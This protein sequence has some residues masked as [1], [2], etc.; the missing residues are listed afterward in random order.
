MD[1]HTLI[2]QLSD[3]ARK[4]GAE[5]L[6]FYRSD[7]LDIETKDD[8]SPVTAADHAANAVIVEALKTL[9]PEIPIISEEGGTHDATQPIEAS[10]FWLVDPLDGTKSFIK[11][12]GE[13][14]VNIALIDDLRPVLGVV[15]VPAQGVMYT[16]DVI[17]KHATRQK[18]EGSEEVIT[19][20]APSNDGLDV[21][22]S[23]SH[24]VKETEAYLQ[25]QKIRNAVSAA[26]SLKFC[27]VAEGKADLYPRFGPTMEWD[28]AA[29]HA[30]LAAAGGEVVTPENSPFHYAKPEFRNGFFIARA[31]A[32]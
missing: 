9:T 5:T 20:R 26:S 18:D 12:K 2:S 32:V 29:G 6:R 8:N 25:G 22:M 23:R 14:T 28:T 17:G 16:G 21:V 15:Y 7:A 10:R 19:V 13:F 31:Q 24:G 4:A 11:G 30:V 27:V 1:T 3:I